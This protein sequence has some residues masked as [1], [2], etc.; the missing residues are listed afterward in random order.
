MKRSALF[1]LSVFIV[2][3]ISK[4]AAQP[5]QGTIFIDPD[6]IT[7]SD[8]STL[9]STT[10]EGQGTR[11]VFDR[12]VSDWVTINAYL[13]DIT[14]ND[15][16]ISEAQVNPEFGSV[17]A[18]TTEAEKY[19]L[20]IGRL[21]ACLRKDVD[22]IWIHQGTQ[23]FGGGNNSILIHTG[24][25][26][27]YE[28]QGILEE[29]LVHEAAHTSLDASHASAAGW[30]SAQASDPSFI[31][32]YAASNSKSEDIAES[33]LTWLAVRQCQTR[34][35]TAN[36]NKIMQAIPNR[37]KYFDDQ[38]FEM[39]PLCFVFTGVEEIGADAFSVYPNPTP[40][41]LNI[42]TGMRN[43]FQFA[44]IFNMQGELIFKQRLTDAHRTIFA[45]EF[46]NGIYLLVL[47]TTAGQRHSVKWI[48]N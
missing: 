6:I 36:H 10:Y 41:L 1:K 11:T 9:I 48:R 22:A 14:W 20:I 5:Y 8:S 16:L 4:F 30:I 17:A 44:E 33:F 45:H 42:D 39:Y 13:F 37:V 31:S 21:P 43:D 32:T 28:A 25:S 12:R 24:Q 23:P 34:I 2:A 38:N 27:S 35:S 46:V 26:A 18:A 7:D 19:A 3:L 47:T 29:T 15:G 40:G